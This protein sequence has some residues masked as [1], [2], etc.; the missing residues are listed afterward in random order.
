MGGLAAACAAA[1]LSFGKDPER[2]NIIWIMSDDHA[3][4]ALSVYGG[5]INRTPNLDRLAL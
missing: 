4:H 3:R 5:K 2:P 1:P